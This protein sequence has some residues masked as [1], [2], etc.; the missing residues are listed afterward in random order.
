MKPQNWLEKR[1]CQFCPFSLMLLWTCWKAVHTV[2]QKQADLLFTHDPR[3]SFWCAL[4]AKMIGIKVEHIAYSFNFPSLPQGFKYRW[5]KT[6]YKSIT[7]FVVYSNIEKQLYHEYFDIPLER[8]DVCLWSVKKPH[9]QPKNPLES[10]DYIC[11]IG[12]NARDYQ[13][14]MC[15]M[16]QL[17]HI[18]LILV[19]RP[20]N[21]KNLLVPP[22]VKILVDIPNAQAMNILQYSRFMVLPL[23]GT[24]VPCGHVT[25]VAA[26]HLAKAFIVTNSTGVSDYA[27]HYH[28]GIRC[29]PFMP[30][31]LARAISTLWNDT[32]KCQKLGENGIKFA[33]KHCS[34]ETALKHL[35]K[36]LLKRNLVFDY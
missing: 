20:H 27:L 6:V 34:E 24:A 15:A 29:E 18:Q 13:T 19:A 12:G 30:D 31:A 33:K 7:Q 4:F 26:M 17:P 25:L 35:Q 28:N 32:D 23:N 21:L 3:I 5:M 22:N 14:L 36:L 16:Q 9:I 10:Q 11:A 2:Q 8:F 1:F